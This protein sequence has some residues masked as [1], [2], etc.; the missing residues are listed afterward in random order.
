MQTLLGIDLGTSSIKAMLLDT[1][2]GVIGIESQKYD[3]EIPAANCAE[4]NPDHWWNATIELCSRLKK[5]YQEAFGQ[6]RGIGLSGQMHGLVTVDKQGNILRPAIIW[7]DQRSCEEVEEINQGMT[8]D[9][10]KQILH[11]RIYPGF[12]FPSLLWIKKHEPDLYGQISKIMQPKDY[13]R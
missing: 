1:E 5:K 8:E 9:E 13:I 6:I 7:L 11:N 4:Q 10:K 2:R 3:V 12:A